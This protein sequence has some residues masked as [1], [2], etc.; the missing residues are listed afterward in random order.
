MILK[1]KSQ[2]VLPEV[3]AT[4]ENN[5]DRG[6]IFVGVVEDQPQRDFL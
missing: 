1:L 2:N 4:L 5:V 6:G 3:V